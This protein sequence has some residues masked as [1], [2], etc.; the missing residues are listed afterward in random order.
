LQQLEKV[1]KAKKELSRNETELE[2]KTFSVNII[3][4]KEQETVMVKG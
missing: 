3:M 2:I 4:P 1:L